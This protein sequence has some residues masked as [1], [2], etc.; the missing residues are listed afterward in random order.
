[1]DSLTVL[2]YITRLCCAMKNKK[3][4]IWHRRLQ[5][6]KIKRLYCIYLLLD[7]S[8][9]S[10]AANVKQRKYWTRPIFV[11]QSRSSQGASNNLIRELEENDTDKFFNYLRMTPETFHIEHK[12]VKQHVIRTPISPRTRLEI[13]VR[14]LASGDSMTSLSYTFRIGLNI[15]SQIIS[16]T[17]T[18]IWNC[19][20]Y[21]VLAV[22]TDDTWREFAE[23][24]KL[25]WN[26]PHCVGAIDGKHIIIEVVVVVVVDTG[27][28]KPSK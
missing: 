7:E 11:E 23:G 5:R 19:L 2:L 6:R 21:F 13:T 17:C 27:W 28:L 4:S 15:V 24:F 1:M 12:I 9:P 14:Y 25:K 8:E 10:A 20:K 3:Q 18:E 26:F 22:P 16:E